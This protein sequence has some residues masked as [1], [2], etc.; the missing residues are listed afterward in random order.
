[1]TTVGCVPSNHVFGLHA[2]WH[3]L[4]GL[5]F[6]FWYR[7]FAQFDVATEQD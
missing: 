6:W 7:Y 1:M 3:L 5:G 4:G 2:L